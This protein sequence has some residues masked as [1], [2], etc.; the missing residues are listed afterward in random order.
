MGGVALHRFH[1]IGDE[2]VAA[3]ELYLDL[4]PPVL[5]PVTH[6]HQTVVR[7]HQVEADE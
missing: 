7:Q 1:Q 5:D 2:I 6:F 3:L 4:G